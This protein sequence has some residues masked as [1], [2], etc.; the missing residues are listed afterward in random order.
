MTEYI[1]ETSDKRNISYM[2][3]DPESVKRRAEYAGHKV[4]RVLP[5]EQ[6]DAELNNSIESRVSA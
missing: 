6:W 2:D 4:I 1:A 5:A 3:D